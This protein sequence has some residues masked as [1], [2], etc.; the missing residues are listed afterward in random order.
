MRHRL[1]RHL[2][3][4][5]ALLLAVS[6][7]FC[8]CQDDSI[9]EAPIPEGMG[10]VKVSIHAVSPNGGTRAATDNYLNPN[11]P[12]ELIHSYYVVFVNGE[13]GEGTVTEIVSEANRLA[14]QKTI[15]VDGVERDE[16]SFITVPGKY[17]VYGFANLTDAQW[18]ALG[19][20]KGAAFP[21]NISDVTTT[22]T[23]TNGTPNGK[24]YDGTKTSIAMTSHTGGQSVTVVQGENQPFDVEV[25]RTMAK[26]ELNFTNNTTQPIQIQGFEMYP[27]TKSTVP[28]L[29]PASVPITNADNIEAHDFA[30]IF[31]QLD[32]PA[33][34]GKGTR[35]FYVSETNASSTVI[36]NEYSLRFKVK[37]NNEYEEIRYGFTMNE[38]SSGF[39]NICRN[40]WIKIPITFSDWRLRLEVLAFVPIGGYPAATL[41]YL[42]E[43]NA[44]FSTGGWIVIKP[45]IEKFTT[46]GTETY[47]L[48]SSIVK[49]TDGGSVTADDTKLS[50]WMTV[51]YD[52]VNIFDTAPSLQSDGTIIAELSNTKKG[53]ATVTMELKI[54]GFIYQF[55]FNITNK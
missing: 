22:I 37:R 40:D 13:N 24:A 45:L 47:E 32:L 42:D 55:K 5:Q 29:E 49:T 52:G 30:S 3:R 46:D 19:I 36:Q 35:T 4:L 39:T 38:A 16:F 17:K 12:C 1:N 21:D 43:L 14:A 48:T 2:V 9:E 34:T 27:L 6:A 8:A 25:V 23:S 20:A 7:T 51:D 18:L 26:L 53:R 41:D 33:S 10:R 31:T 44:V 15:P 50:T 11:D 28:L 54:N